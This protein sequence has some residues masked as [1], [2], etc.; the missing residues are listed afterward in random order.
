MRVSGLLYPFSNSTA[1]EVEALL[2]NGQLVIHYDQ[3]RAARCALD[4]VS[5]S[6]QIPGVPVQATL[7]SGERFVPHS[8][9]FIWPIS[10]HRQGMAK[11]ERHYGMILSALLL[12]PLLVYVLLFKVTP[13]AAVL[14]VDYVPDSIVETMGE[15]SMYVVE[16]NF[17]SPSA[18]PPQTQQEIHAIW[19]DALVKVALSQKQYQLGI[20]ASEHFGANAFA[21]PHGQVVITDDLISALKDNPDAIRAVLLH[22][23]GHVEGKHSIRL[24]AQAFAG[25]IAM[26]FIFGDMEGILE[27]LIGSGNLI[28]GAQFSQKMEWEADNFALERLT[29]LGHSNTDFADALK[30]LKTLSETDKD[31]TS[32]RAQWLEYLSTHP[33]LEA[34]I[35]HAQSYQHNQ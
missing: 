24:A 16:E 33:S 15:Q 28:M 27:L 26:S 14:I 9:D 21:L 7:P 17:L 23:I 19:E 5:L 12:T 10:A 20:Y 22:E 25:T 8:P 30:H 32:E 3:N 6:T 2:E 31:P 4:N 35:Q 18:L 34:R 11:F 13:M 1:Y 29:Q